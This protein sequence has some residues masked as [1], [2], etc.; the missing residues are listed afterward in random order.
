M[1]RPIDL[2]LLRTFAAVAELGR[3]SQAAKA[4]QL[5]KSTVSRHIARLEQDLDRALFRRTSDGFNMTCDGR[6]LFEAAH[7]AVL[8]LSD[9]SSGAAHAQ[10]RVR[11]H[12]PAVYTHGLLSKVLPECMMDMADVSI[13]ICVD[14]R[15]AVPDPRQ[16]DLVVFVGQVPDKNCE[17][18]SL[19]AVEARLYAS[20]RLFSEAA[21]PMDVP[22]LL[23]WPLLCTGG[24]PELPRSLRLSDG[25]ETRTA[26]FRSARLISEDPVVLARAAAAGVGI[27]RLPCFLGRD[28]VHSGELVSVLPHLVA[29]RHCVTLARSFRNTNPT[30]KMVAHRLVTAI[31]S[32]EA[33]C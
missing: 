16:Y 21:P 5:P 9:F 24:N 10:S 7:P 18:W 20:P 29:D 23:N 30:A 8:A 6:R 17:L 12:A 22:D 2:N 1:N 11:I 15:F 3:I 27:A 28:F 33:L 4:L 13:E 32:G 19:P 25:R 14:E 31:G 26:Q